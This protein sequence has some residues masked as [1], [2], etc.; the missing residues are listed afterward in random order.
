MSRPQPRAKAAGTHRAPT[1]VEEFGPPDADATAGTA[2]EQTVLRLQAAMGSLGT[3]ALTRMEELLPWFRQLSAAQRSSIGLVA[4]AGISAFVAWFTDAERARMQITSEVF[5]NAPRELVRAVSLQQTVAMV[6]ATIAVVEEHVEELAPPQ[7]VQALREAALQYSREIA[8]A[9]A[10][11][12]AGAAEA[13]GAWDA[14]LEALVI[15]ALLRGDPDTDVGSRAAALGWGPVHGVCVVVGH[16]PARDTA[17]V[18]ADVQRAC[19]SHNWDL[20]VGVHGDTMVAV[21]GGAPDPERAARALSAHFGSGPLVVSPQVPTLAEAPQA[22]A[23][24]LAGLRAARAWPAAPRPV[25]ADLLLPERA[26]AGDVLARSR[27]VSDVEGGLGAADSALRDTL[28]AFLDR[29]GAIE[30]TARA[31]YVHPNTVRYRLRRITELTGLNPSAARDA[32][33]LRLGLSYGRLADDSSLGGTPPAASDGATPD[34]GL[35]ALRP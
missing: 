21:L 2:H 25:A 15:D 19:R 29:S 27:L 12:Y 26:L 31:L 13:R 28:E 20:L 24:A 17:D 3:A 5:G 6:R 9:A 14:R 11:V 7:G 10:E 4:Q 23:Q 30:A 22:A 8:F 32:F 1:P 16:P 34:S 18:I 35:P 33:A